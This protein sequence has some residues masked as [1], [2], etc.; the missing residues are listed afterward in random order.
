MQLPFCTVV[1]Y[2]Q[3]LVDYLI[4]QIYTDN[5]VVKD[6]FSFLGSLILY[7]QQ[8]LFNSM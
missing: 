4:K 6:H 8:D 1:R 3:F 7:K 2:R 5:L